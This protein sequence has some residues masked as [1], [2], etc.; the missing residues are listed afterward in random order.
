MR[1]TRIV[2]LIL[3]AFTM[4]FCSLSTAVATGFVPTDD[5]Q[6]R[7]GVGSRDIDDPQGLKPMLKKTI[8]YLGDNNAN[9]TNNPDTLLDNDDTQDLTDLYR[10]YLELQGQ[11]RGIDLVLVLDESDSMNNIDMT[12]NAGEAISRKEALLTYLNGEDGSGTGFIY[13]FLSI[14]AANRISIAGFSEIGKIELEWT[15]ADNKNATADYTLRARTTSYVDGL[16]W[17]NQLLSNRGDSDNQPLVIFLGDGAAN[18]AYTDGL[19]HNGNE[20]NIVTSDSNTNPWPAFYVM[21]Q[22][23]YYYVTEGT[24]YKYTRNLNPDDFYQEYLRSTGYEPYHYSDRYYGADDSKIIS[25]AL[26]DLQL[27]IPG[28]EAPNQITDADA[29]IDFWVNVVR[30]L[31]YYPANSTQEQRDEVDARRLALIES[32]SRGTPRQI[33]IWNLVKE[34]FLDFKAS[35][36]NATVYSIGFSNEMDRTTIDTNGKPR[37][38]KE[39]LEYFADNASGEYYY[40]ENLAKLADAI[41]LINFKLIMTNVRLTDGMSPYVHIYGQ[42][43]LKIVRT[44]NDGDNETVLYENGQLTNTGMEALKSVS[45]ENGKLT[46]DFSDGYVIPEYIYT[47]S[48]NVQLTQKAYEQYKTSGYDARGD[49]LTDYDTIATSSNIEGFYSNSSADSLVTWDFLGSKDNAA[50]F[51]KPV[52]QVYMTIEPPATGSDTTIRLIFI[53]LAFSMIGSASVV[54]AARNRR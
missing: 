13:D 30:P 14:N 6:N 15:G 39:V 23:I 50:F 42:D 41:D 53:G 35:N 44:D 10:L 45:L 32:I 21:M 2:V 5:N 27:E 31:N 51:P 38:N 40:A 29:V 34:A 19:M 52:V 12:N 33:D 9:E 11:S 36:P 17:A 25:Y 43:E 48:F 24:Y 54:I 46:I 7:N 22:S 1:K 16:Y 8:D 49:D 28:F 20:G 18:L 3:A 37:S 26:R 47:A 4:P